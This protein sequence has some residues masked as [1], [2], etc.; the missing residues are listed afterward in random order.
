MYMHVRRMYMCMQNIPMYICTRTEI[1]NMYIYIYVR[2]HVYIYICI[3]VYMII[4]IYVRIYVRIFHICI[5]VYMYICIYAR[6]N[7]YMQNSSRPRNAQV[8]CVCEY[9]C[10]CLC[11]YLHIFTHCTYM[12]SRA[13]VHTQKR[14]K[15]R[16]RGA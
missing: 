8:V 16:E 7:A 13:H 3:Y 2:I 12:C 15:A 11:V 5:N 1:V 9:V 6:I 14:I 10:V 4:C